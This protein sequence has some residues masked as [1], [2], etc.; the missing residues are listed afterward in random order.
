MGLTVSGLVSGIDVDS[1]VEQLSEVER[2]PIEKL[3]LQEAD[4]QVR[5]TA[6]SNLEGALEEL[7]SSMMGLDTGFDFKAFLASSGDEEVFTATAASGAIQ[8]SYNVTVHQL[9]QSHKIASDG[10]DDSPVGG[11][12]LH[13]TAGPG[14]TADIE[15]SATDT[16]DDVAEAINESGAG[17]N[18]VVISDGTS[19]FLSLSSS[20]TGENQ[21]ITVTVSGD[22]DG[23]DTDNSGLSRLYYDPTYDAEGQPVSGS[24]H[25]TQS[26]KAQ[27]AIISVDGIDNI[28]RDS[29]TIDDAIKGV[30][31]TLYKPHEDPLNESSLLTVNR[32]TG[33]IVEKFEGFVEKYNQLLEFFDTVQRKP[34]EAGQTTGVLFNDS[35]I[36]RIRKTLSEAIAGQITVGENIDRLADLGFSLNEQNMLEL[37]SS[38]LTE[39]INNNFEE[40]VDFFTTNEA[41]GPKGFAV[42]L[43]D[44]IDAMLETNTGVLS[45]RQKGIQSSIDR[46][47]ERVTDIETRVE[48]MAERTRRQF[49][50]LELLL[51]QYQATSDFLAQQLVGL[52][53][54]SNAISKK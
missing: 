34:D 20:Q 22:A 39:A 6:Y 51:G 46:I 52:D 7:R 43:V 10:F 9:A 12:T 15:V 4:Y 19:K 50:N 17:V 1:L 37:T 16:I 18:A 29:N 28:V 33:A 44:S 14:L 53:N 32:D 8:G 2:K 5:L 3:S 54:L 38:K 31:L 40:V 41:E 30:T 13:L 25:L 42:K 26:Q 24:Y 11:G 49:L 47:Q 21:R 36:K 23:S 48:N 45:A 35:T 27:N